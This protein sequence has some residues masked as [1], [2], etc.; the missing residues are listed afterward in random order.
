MLSS[1]ITKYFTCVTTVVTNEFYFTTRNFGK[2][3][4]FYTVIA[5]LAGKP[6]KRA[7]IQQCLDFLHENHA[8]VGINGLGNFKHKT[9]NI[10]KLQDFLSKAGYELN[11]TG[12]ET[13]GSRERLY[14]LVE[15][16]AVK[17]YADNR[18]RLK[19]ELL[20]TDLAMA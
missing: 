12:R 11:E 18:K 4:Y 3:F 13:T 9:S 6:V 10:R 19:A 20:E 14:S 16:K 15:N 17:T 7:L 1:N 8:E 2:L 5:N